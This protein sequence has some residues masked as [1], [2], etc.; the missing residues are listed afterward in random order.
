MLNGATQ[1]TRCA[2]KRVGSNYQWLWHDSI[3]GERSLPILAL[4]V[5]L[6]G[7]SGDQLHT[8]GV[9]ARSCVFD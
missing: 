9:D 2:L 5:F 1:R 4:I 7:A 3:F 8:F 6:R